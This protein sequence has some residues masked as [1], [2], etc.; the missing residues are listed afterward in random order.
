MGEEVISLVNVSKR[1]GGNLVLKDINLSLN[2][3][4]I[5]GITGP[6]GSGK[7]VLIKILMDFLKPDK[8]T[9]RINKKIGFSV[10]DNSLYEN[11]TLMQNLKYFSK[12]YNVKNIED[13]INYLLRIL[14]LED[15]KDKLVFN[16]SG[17]TKKRLD[18]ACALLNSPEI[19]IL[20]EPFVGLDCSLI[21]QLS[22]F[23]SYLRDNG[24]T[25]VMS[26][27]ILDPIETLCDKV[28]FI[29]NGSLDPIQK[30]EIRKKY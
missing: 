1:Y 9:V 21:S 26:S 12:L 14:V 24:M 29:K 23:L 30:L 28:V 2:K 20:D 22:S 13:K 11:L 16:L 19:L 17:G 18:I 3:Q 27:H 25:I 8:G 6:S 7:T 4:E 5:L 15:Y 10:Q